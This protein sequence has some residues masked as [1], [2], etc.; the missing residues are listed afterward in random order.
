MN[1]YALK[2]LVIPFFFLLNISCITCTQK[3]DQIQNNLNKNSF[4][5]IEL[6]FASNPEC[7]K[8]KDDPECQEGKQKLTASGVV[9]YTNKKEQISYILTVKHICLN[10]YV[11]SAYSKKIQ[12]SFGIYDIEGNHYNGIPTFVHKTYDICLVKVK[13]ENNILVDGIISKTKPQYADK[14]YMMGATLSIFG[15]QTV[16]FFEGR[17]AGVLFNDEIRHDFYTI[18]AAKGASGA[19]IVNK[20]GEIVGIINSIMQE[21]HHLALAVPFE[22]L[23]EIGTLIE[24]LKTK[25]REEEVKED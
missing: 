8:D 15:K 3:T 6:T 1:L 4:T 25:D 9:I 16:P 12:M 22:T 20:D 2:K 19:A 24:N 14:V 21:F 13:N 18:P 7:E 5:Y 17:Y 10:D 11:R 23:T